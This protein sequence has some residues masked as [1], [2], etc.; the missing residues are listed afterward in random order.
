MTLENLYL[1]AALAGLGGIS[2]VAN[3]K[4]GDPLIAVITYVLMLASIGGI[5]AV[6]I[7]SLL[8]WSFA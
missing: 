7:A 4:A 6:T 2:L 8:G 5:A 3:I 1:V